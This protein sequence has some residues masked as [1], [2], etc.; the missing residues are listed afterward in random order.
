MKKII[1]LSVE[2]SIFL[3]SYF[4]FFNFSNDIR[5]CRREKRKFVRKETQRE[6]MMSVSYPYIFKNCLFL[7]VKHESR[8]VCFSYF[9]S[10]SRSI[11]MKNIMTY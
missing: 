2:F 3:C 10:L 8:N 4:F 9:F 1:F 5:A 11:E 7:Q 6:K